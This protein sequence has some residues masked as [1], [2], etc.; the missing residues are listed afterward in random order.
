LEK[1]IPEISRLYSPRA[2]IDSISNSGLRL[3]SNFVIPDYPEY[4]LVLGIIKNLIEW[5]YH[6]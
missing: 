3:K 1:K 2:C 5:E 6:Y 4:G